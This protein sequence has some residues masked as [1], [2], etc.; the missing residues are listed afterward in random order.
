MFFY[1]GLLNVLDNILV[2]LEHH[3]PLPFSE[4]P[5]RYSNAV[6]TKINSC[7]IS[8]FYYIKEKNTSKLL[9]FSIIIMFEPFKNYIQ[10]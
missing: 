10:K 8:Y 2:T 5:L 3:F 4:C 9:A 1:L 6:K 7:E